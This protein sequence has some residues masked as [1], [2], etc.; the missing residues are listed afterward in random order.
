MIYHF[1]LFNSVFSDTNSS[2]LESIKGNISLR[3][4]LSTYTCF[5]LHHPAKCLDMLYALL[6]SGLRFSVGSF[7]FLGLMVAVRSPLCA[8]SARLPQLTHLR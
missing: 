2:C 4:W 1:F 7:E 6:L 8:R 3:S 5:V